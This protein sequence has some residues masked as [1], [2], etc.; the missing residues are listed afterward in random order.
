MMNQIIFSEKH[1][2][3]NNILLIL[4]A[5]FL[6]FRLN[7]SSA[8]SFII[9]FV[10]IYDFIKFKDYFLK[11]LSNKYFKIG[12]LLYLIHILGLVYTSNF[13]YA[14]TDLEIKLPL[15]IFPL[16]VFGYNS[17][18]YDLLKRILFGFVLGCFSVGII[19]ISHSYYVY[20]QTKKIDSFF[21][22]GITYF[23]H[24]SYFSMYLMF[25]IFLV[26]FF[27]FRKKEVDENSKYKLFAFFLISFFTLIIILLSSRA[28]LI[29][30]V[31]SF[32]FLIIYL[33]K[34]RKYF[35]PSLVMTLGI[36]SIMMVVKFAPKAL[37]RFQSLNSKTIFYN[38]SSNVKEDINKMDQRLAILEI[39]IK[40]FKRN[41]IIGVGTGDIKDVLL[42]EYKKNNFIMGFNHKLNCHNQ[43][44]QFLL[45]FGL[46]GL[47]VF[48]ISLSVTTYYAFLEKKNIYIFLALLL[49]FN[50]LFESM[51]E[52]KA[53]VEF[54]GFFCAVLLVQL[55]KSSDKEAY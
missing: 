55:N 42:S 20:L 2:K 41:P 54:F 28:G 10:F 30:L 5:F 8:I 33:I 29:S 3:F 4:F 7:I 51:L 40:L 50:F 9:L 6:P 1:I 19:S 52:T 27:V 38:K 14:L 45:A 15:L 17:M 32:L 13:K 47:V 16:V 11:S 12:I 21:Y 34:I 44:I 31:L 22:G 36:F 48:L 46:V 18:N 37:E 39:S 23:I 35:M 26:Y 53:G 43:F 24:S 49:S 25:S